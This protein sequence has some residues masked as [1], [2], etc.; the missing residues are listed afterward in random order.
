MPSQAQI[1]QDWEQN[2]H[3]PT[4]QTG[5]SPQSQVEA[6]R[7]RYHPVAFVLI[8]LTIVFILDFAAYL[9]VAPATR[10][11]ED[12][13]CRSYYDEH[14]PD[15][16]KYPHEIP[17]DQC[18]INPVQG[19]VALVQGLGASFDAIPSIL[20]AIP[21]GRLSDNPKFGRKKVLVLSMLGLVLN[22]WWSVLV[23]WFPHI[24]PL[25]AVWFGS[26]FNF[27]GGGLAVANAMI[28]TMIG[29][30]IDSDNRATAFFQLG[31]APVIAQL[32][33][34]SVSSWMMQHE[35]VRPA[36]LFATGCF[37]AGVPLLLLLPE[38]VHLRFLKESDGCDRVVV[39]DD[40]SQVD[41]PK[42][43][44]RALFHGLI[45][46]TSFVTRN[47]PVLLL[48]STFF[49][50]VLGRSQ[51]NL[52]LQYVSKRYQMP[53]SKASL[54]L[55]L[56]AAMNIVMLF[57][58][59]PAASRYLTTR[60]HFSPSSKDLW[61][62]KMSVIALILG[63]FVLGISPTFAVMVVGLAVYSVGSG[64]NA[65]CLSMITTFIDAEYTARLYSIVVLVSTMGAFVGAPTLAALFNAGLNVGAEWAGL[66][67]V[68]SG[69]LHVFIA[70]A[71]W[72]V[73]LPKSASALSSSTASQEETLV[74][75]EETAPLLPTDV[76]G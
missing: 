76:D 21:F 44:V 70:V 15:R 67:F 63:C 72:F 34:P 9:L 3:L 4:T 32:I 59:L 14:D 66:P 54:A 50:S 74:D 68:A 26:I 20:L 51:I 23:C 5:E 69:L 6:R 56:Y 31:L 49:L 57:L 24:F 1:D 39:E 60:L 28:I 2:N 30:I 35:G 37:T 42:G 17:E 12:I 33:A 65:V 25:R 73:R 38:T 48:L 58:L 10:L 64:F 22:V 75:E 40:A 27:I 53:L 46:S 61:M 47:R 16:F 71:L 13:A 41:P 29:D 18:K 52:L 43:R 11:F 62:S 45:R 36:Y 8:C 55:S 19:E 7:G